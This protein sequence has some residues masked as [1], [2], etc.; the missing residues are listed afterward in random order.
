MGKCSRNLTKD[1]RKFK[2]LQQISSLTPI[3]MYAHT[4]AY[5]HNIHNI[6]T[7]MHAYVHPYTC[8]LFH[9]CDFSS[10]N[11]LGAHPYINSHTNNK[12][13]PHTFAPSWLGTFGQQLRVTCAYFDANFHGH[14]LCIPYIPKG[15][16]VMPP[17]TC[18]PTCYDT[19]TNL[20]AM[21]LKPIFLDW[22]P[23]VQ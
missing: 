22:D 7:Y 16:S 2:V 12:T 4:H 18:Q 9:K 13:Y 10:R 20:K 11:S 1:E 8:A 21:T 6:H 15:E 19:A 5:I 3:R 14:K 17:L 23:M